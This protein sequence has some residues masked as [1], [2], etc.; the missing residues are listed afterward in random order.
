MIALKDPLLR[1]PIK[2]LQQ[3]PGSPWIQWKNNSVMNPFSLF[4]RPDNPRPSEVGEMM[5]DLGLIQLQGFHEITHANF[6]LAD[7]IEY[8]KARCVL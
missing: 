1:R 2:G 4:S 8:A 6:P 3:D 5:R 7:Q